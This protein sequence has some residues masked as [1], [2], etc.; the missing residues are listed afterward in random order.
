MHVNARTKSMKATMARTMIAAMAAPSRRPS[1]GR[2]RR[3]RLGPAGR[4][5]PGRDVDAP[6]ADEE[7]RAGH[8]GY[9]HRGAGGDADAV[10]RLGL[11]R[12]T[13]DADEA[14]GVL[15]GRD[16][17]HD[18]GGAAL[19]AVG[20]DRVHLVAAFEAAPEWDEGGEAD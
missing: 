19:P 9:E 14:G 8:V 16:L 18:G 15:P 7:T 13:V 10:G 2:R 20:A 17:V 1:A 5:S 11:P 3:A 6:R 12:L 4:G